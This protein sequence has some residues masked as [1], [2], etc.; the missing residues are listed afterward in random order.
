MRH[1]ESREVH[2]WTTAKWICE[3]DLH[4]HLSTAAAVKCESNPNARDSK[5]RLRNGKFS[6]EATD[7]DA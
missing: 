5:G 6:G 2:Y 3:G 1:L 4:E 7:G